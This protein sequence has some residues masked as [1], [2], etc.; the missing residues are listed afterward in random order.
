MIK[1]GSKKSA[2]D[3]AILKNARQDVERL[4]RFK[5]AIENAEAAM[6]LVDRDLVIRSVNKKA[7]ELF[8]DVIDA[9]R[10]NWP[11]FDPNNLIGECI[12]KFHANPAHQRKIL[13]DH[14][15]LPFVTGYITR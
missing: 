14:R 3:A 8:E 15:N 4:L 12:D 10:A 5:Y 1:L 7:V 6:L 13:S 11:D 2:Q 9:I